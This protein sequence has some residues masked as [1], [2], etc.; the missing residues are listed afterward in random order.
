M[1][2]LPGPRA[3]A[4]QLLLALSD[5]RDA[6]TL[7]WGP[8]LAIVYGL[9]GPVLSLKRSIAKRSRFRRAA[10]AGLS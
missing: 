8:R 5:R 6:L 4:R 9:L 1:R 3:R 2:L 10:G 7:Q